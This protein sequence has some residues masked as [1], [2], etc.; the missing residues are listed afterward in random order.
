[1]RVGFGLAFASLCSIFLLACGS[2]DPA[3]EQVRIRVFEVVEASATEATL[4][5]ETSGATALR[6]LAEDEEVPLGKAPVAAGSIV[7]QP[8]E[9][10][11]Y[12]LIATG[13]GGRAE[14]RVEVTIEHAPPTVSLTVE[15]D[16]ID[17]GQSATLSWQV[18]DA[19]TI[20]L[21]TDGGEV[22][23][24]GEA[25]GSVEVEPERTTTYVLT[26]TG[27]GGTASEERTLGVHP[28][29]G[30]L[31][32]PTTPVHPSMEVE[33]A[34]ETRGATEVIL[35]N[36]DGFQHVAT[37]AS[38]SAGSVL[39]PVGEGGRFV[40]RARSGGLEAE[41]ELRLDVVRVP[42]VGAFEATPVT[43]SPDAPAE[44]TVSW[45]V[46][47]AD[48][49]F[50]LGDVFAEPVPVDAVGSLA[51][52][53]GAPTSFQLTASN[54]AGTVNWDVQARVLPFSVVRHFDAFPDVVEMG[55]PVLL[56]WEVEHAAAIEI[57]EV[58]GDRV[59]VEPSRF[60]GTASHP[61][62]GDTT[63]R[64]HAVNELG[65]EVEA[66][67]DVRIGTLFVTDFSFPD[68]VAPGAAVE[69]T[70]RTEAAVSVELTLDGEEIC[71]TAEPRR[72]QEGSCTFL[73]PD[74][75]GSYRLHLSARGPTGTTVGQGRPIRVDDAPAISLFQASREVA[76][77]GDTVR[78]TFLVGRDL[79]GNLADVELLG[80]DGEPIAIDVAQGYVDV[81][82]EAA[83]ART[84]TLIASSAEAQGTDERSLVVQVH[85]QPRIVSFTSDPPFVS[86][87]SE[88]ITLSWQTEHAV[89]LRVHELQDGSLGSTV[90]TET[91]Q[92]S[93][94]AGSRTIPWRPDL[95]MVVENAAGAEARIDLR[96]GLD[97]A[98]ILSFDATPNPIARGGTATLS[99]QTL[100]AQGLAIEHAPY[101]ESD[102]PF[103]DIRTSPTAVELPVLTSAYDGRLFEFPDGFVFPY[104]GS[105]RTGAVAMGHAY[106]A[107]D[108]KE[109]GSNSS[110]PI[111]RALPNDIAEAHLAPFWAGTNVGSQGA[112]IWYD[113]RTDGERRHLVIQFSDFSL[114]DHADA[115]LEF[116]IVLWEDGS[117]DYRYGRMTATDPDVAAGAVS[118]IGFQSMDRHTGFTLLHRQPF[119]GGLAGRS[120][121]FPA[122]PFEI[123]VEPAPPYVDVS[124][125][126]GAVQL[127]PGFATSSYA[128]LDPLP[129]GFVFP[130][131]GAERT[132]LQ[133]GTSGWITFDT[134]NSS[135]FFSAERLAHGAQI[136]TTS[137]VPHLAP[138]WTGLT[139]GTT[140]SI[141]AAVT[142][143]AD[144]PALVVQWSG[145]HL[146]GA[147]GADDQ[148]TSSL[149][150]Q[151]WLRE[152]GRFEYRYGTMTHS[153]DPGLADGSGASIG[154]QGP[155]STWGLQMSFQTPWE[156]GLSGESWRFVPELLL[157]D[158]GSLEVA[159]RGTVAY[160]LRASD[161]IHAAEE[162]VELVVHPPQWVQSWTEP[163]FP[164]PHE[165]MTLHWIAS[166]L[167]TLRI[168][169][170]DGQVLHVAGP[171]ELEAGQLD[172][173]AGLEAGLYTFTFV[174]AGLM[175]PL[176]EEMTALVAG[177]FEIVSFGGDATIVP[178]D[179]ATLSWAVD[180]A[181]SVTI[182]TLDG[183]DVGGPGLDPAAGSLEV[184]PQANTTYV[185]RAESLG[186]EL[187]A[188]WAVVVR[189]VQ[190]E[191]LQAS[192]REIPLGG[193]VTLDWTATGAEATLSKLTMME[194][195]EAYD[196]ISVLGGVSFP[197]GT[198]PTIQLP[199]AFPYF[200]T[201]Y[202]SVRAG[203][204]LVSLGGAESLPPSSVQA[205]PTSTT[206]PRPRIAAFWHG[207]L[208]S[209]SG[210][211]S[212]TLHVPGQDGAPD[213]F[214]LQWSGY[215]AGSLTGSTVNFQLV[216]FEDG[217]IEFRYGEMTGTTDAH[218][219]RADGSE[220]SIGFQNEDGS[221]GYQ[222][223][224]RTPMEGGLS[225]RSFRFQPTL[226][227]PLTFQPTESETLELCV[228]DDN[229]RECESIRV[230]VVRPGD[231]AFTEVMLAPLW[232]QSEQWF[233]L[234]NLGPD[235][236]DLHG[237]V[238]QVGTTTHTLD[239][240]QP[241]Y[242]GTGEYV[243]FAETEGIPAGS[244]PY[245][246]HLTLG[247]HTQPGSL[248]L[249]FGALEVA[250]FE[251]DSTWTWTP[252]VSRELRANLHK[253]GTAQ[254]EQAAYC[255]AEA[256]YDGHQ[257]G[258][259]GAAGA[260]CTDSNYLVELLADAPFVDIRAVGT[261]M[262]DISG[263]WTKQG[264][265]GGLGFDFP[266]FGVTLPASTPVWA[267]SKGYLTFT[268]IEKPA[269][270]GD[271]WGVLSAFDA[272]KSFASFQG[273]PGGSVAPLWSKLRSVPGAEVHFHRD[274]LDGREVL[275]LQWSDWAHYDAGGLMTY[276]VQLWEDGEVVFAFAD[277]EGPREAFGLKGFSAMQAPGPGTYV[278]VVANEAI[279]IP[280]TSIRLLPR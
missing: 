92:E 142:E 126:A 228:E 71:A 214:I 55:H 168:E 140:G 235:P 171:S 160:T 169:D 85:E 175:G 150:F 264:V 223:L 56:D 204:G 89:S 54:S 203:R 243:V 58:G 152:D 18:R 257:A 138:F 275:I 242:L 236:I 230:V 229:H 57:W 192:A 104:E 173:P 182:E 247:S 174:G 86:D 170:E 81:V 43:A 32:G 279:L 53:I 5:W 191:G 77:V 162:T 65:A 62:T 208:P 261:R 132:A 88:A 188:T 278:E 277:L 258:S 76:T 181:D 127:Q 21:E 252:G 59:S 8:P 100:R 136:V 23:A 215:R 97:P 52:A 110:Q 98:E 196:D 155:L 50:L 115:H 67:V 221:A 276:Q 49:I 29:I 84:Y 231:L 159:P 60:V 128:T 234:R 109:F 164:A 200:G 178:G 116:Q 101:V 270:G 233:E 195:G 42:I 108:L 124:G 263:N 268:D 146:N 280:H 134:S 177:N 220:A 20:R 123:E 47:G 25:T 213:A 211:A 137:P 125:V 194:A 90:F 232:A 180:G 113:L 129:D 239:F 41:R 259:P 190:L 148:P 31:E 28:V 158:A 133:V 272:P 205:M 227:P 114:A 251:W 87:A 212:H 145:Y 269:S 75:V 22:I 73:A 273:P 266:F 35:E 33:I 3:P 217:A 207:S 189:T 166:G 44:T 144:G 14:A 70:W 210:A 240:G 185:L 16:T 241:R 111:N 13:P 102:D 256:L 2:D 105:P 40:L 95:R 198:F 147:T 183:V 154:F 267:V 274:V 167:T 226:A 172:F 72:V 1:M 82:M 130:F 254:H 184:F 151:V 38:V 193:S 265:D 51:V 78:L 119:P 248:S 225:H 222:L 218:Q 262:Q 93:I 112:E 99:W 135:G 45:E 46:F 206:S 26:A 15:P 9:T 141:W 7:V 103:V 10:T 197:S 91:T 96:V 79:Y 34:W 6:L 246:G 66:F 202:T 131:R 209:Q 253:R 149:D 224:Y 39:A 11:T 17:F 157:P 64:L 80:P 143:D 121:H 237:K 153:A 27:P 187:S 250:T 120:F 83:G 179:P 219:N 244:I 201:T 19:E 245:G 186:R 260:A 255:H 12:T 36:A 216:L 249:I 199:F 176:V 139:Q 106:L 165:P 118:T 24:R 69:A 238:L 68:R 94:D 156:G 4:R 107:F 61:V 163:A 30:R 271:P 37:G 48:E 161:S 117:F 74:T 122:L 63:F